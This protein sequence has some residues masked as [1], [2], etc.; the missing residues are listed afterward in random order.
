MFVT[1]Q[2]D[3]HSSSPIY[4]IP[5]SPVKR[6]LLFSCISSFLVLTLSSTNLSSLSLFPT[7]QCHLLLKTNETTLLGPSLSIGDVYGDDSLYWIGRHRLTGL[8]T[9]ENNQ[10]SLI[11]FFL[12]DIRV[13]D[14]SFSI[15]ELNS[16]KR[17]MKITSP[18]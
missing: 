8:I 2:L 7:G 15:V 1:M 5:S 6:I 14:V 13:S 16:T 10:C 18:I 9:S 3:L 17:L 12:R 11:G 4:P